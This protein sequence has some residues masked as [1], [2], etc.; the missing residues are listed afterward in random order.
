MSLLRCLLQGA[1]QEVVGG[2]RRGKWGRGFDPHPGHKHVYIHMCMHVMF[3]YINMCMPHVSLKE[4]RAVEAGEQ[5]GS[6]RRV[7]G[8]GP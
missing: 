1:S 3:I 5:G 4:R 2:W 8:P 6:R 7:R